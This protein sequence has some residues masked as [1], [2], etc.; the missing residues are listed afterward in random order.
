MEECRLDSLAAVLVRSLHVCI[1]AGSIATRKQSASCCCCTLVTVAVGGAEGKKALTSR[2]K[3]YCPRVASSEAVLRSK[4]VGFAA[5]NA[6]AAGNRMEVA[7]PRGG[8]AHAASFLF[9]LAIAYH[10]AICTKQASIDAPTLAQVEAFHACYF[11]IGRLPG[12][13]SGRVISEVWW[14]HNRICVGG[15]H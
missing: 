6:A 8:Q 9:I 13:L 2:K 3:R 11:M 1:R 10:V 14:R 12:S 4:R 5:A 7:S 15:L